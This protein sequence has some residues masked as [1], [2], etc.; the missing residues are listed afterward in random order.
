MFPTISIIVP[1]FNASSFI[2]KCAVSLFNQ[3][4]NNLEFIFV[5]DKS[6]DNSV[7]L[8]LEVIS[9][10]PKLESNIKLIRHQSNQ[11]SAIARNTG[12]ENANGLYIGWVDADDWI[13][14]NMFY[15][16]FKKAKD[17]NADLI[18]C[19]FL[20]ISGTS[21]V[22]RKI[23]LIEDSKIFLKE[24]FNLNTPS[25]IWNKIIKR[26]VFVD[27]DIHFLPGKNL[28][29]DFVVLFKVLFFCKK[30]AYVPEYLY[31]YVQDNSKSLS[32]NLDSKKINEIVDNSQAVVK[33]IADYKITEFSVSEIDEFK[34]N[35]KINLLYSISLED[36]KAWV[37]IYPETNYLTFRGRIGLK[38]R[39]LGFLSILRQWYLIKLW[40]Y[41]KIVKNKNS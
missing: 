30:V 20:E 5:D 39:V 40:I 8:L 1:I 3:D 41:F 7:E 29:E 32:R 2:K 25:V 19:D 10:Y 33:F 23:N 9:L 16:L 24:V 27:N 18:W 26:A 37:K 4:L 13:E 34:F 35:S 22:N 36:F 31:N 12:L 21:V 28:G 11:G 17:T 14:P 38:H 15:S 6:T